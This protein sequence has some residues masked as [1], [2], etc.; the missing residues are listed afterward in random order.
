MLT[1]L[2]KLSFKAQTLLQETFIQPNTFN[3]IYLKK[4]TYKLEKL[5]QKLKKIVK[6][7]KQIKKN[8][9]KNLKQ[10][11]KKYDFS[12]TIK[13]LKKET[14]IDLKKLF[15]KKEKFG[16]RIYVKHLIK[17]YGIKKNKLE[18][19]WNTIV[20]LRE[21]ESYL[22][23]FI[24]KGGYFLNLQ[25]NKKEKDERN[26]I[27]ANALNEEIK[28]AKIKKYEKLICINY[29][30]LTQFNFTGTYCLGCKK[31]ISSKMLKYHLE[32]KIHKKY[33]FTVLTPDEDYFN[34][35]FNLFLLTLKQKK[36][37]E[38]Y[39]FHCEICCS[40]NCIKMNSIKQ[41]CKV[42]IK[43]REKHFLSEMHKT[44]LT[45]LN[46]NLEK[47][48]FIFNKEIALN[49][50]NKEEEIEMEDEEGNLYD[51]QTYL[52]LKKLNLI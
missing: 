43:E 46:I 11:I 44:N 14:K 29:D 6:K 30:N 21:V 3:N 51:L 40:E 25:V 37:K 48:N 19:N 49:F 32:S 18:N 15:T 38:K 52:D 27:Y 24:M 26:L 10:K 36:K 4:I 45:N 39:F 22:Y 7:I 2:V 41:N 17:K 12:K 42:C 1:K 20:F 16:K 13:K 5:K 31:E 35:L 9:Y 8:E 34:Y 33:P 47:G 23:D 28:N 50:V